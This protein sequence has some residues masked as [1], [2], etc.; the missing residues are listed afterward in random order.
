MLTVTS[1][2]SGAGLTSRQG[3]LVVSAVPW[4]EVRG[5]VGAN[6]ARVELP[7]TAVTPLRIVLPPGS[8]RVEVVGAETDEAWT[9]DAHI[10]EGATHICHATLGS[11]GVTQYWKEMGWWR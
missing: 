3:V 9:C 1:A 11:V 6:G 2:L 5:V 4:G 8:Y 10:V 7:S